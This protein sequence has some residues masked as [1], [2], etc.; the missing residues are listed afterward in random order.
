MKSWCSV[1]FG[2]FD[3]TMYS[4]S[5][6]LFI[7]SFVSAIVWFG[8]GNLT[9]GLFVIIFLRFRIMD[10]TIVDVLYLQYSTVRKSMN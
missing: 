6:S 9:F 3:D 4:I 10:S 7:F 2:A 8:E 1:L 5:I